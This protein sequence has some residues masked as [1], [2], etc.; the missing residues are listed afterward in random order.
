MKTVLYSLAFALLTSITLNAQ[1]TSLRVYEILQE[2]CASCHSN[3]NPQNGLDLEGSGATISQRATDVANNIKNITPSNEHAAARG[4]RYIYPGRPDRSFLFRKIN[5]GLEPLLHLDAEEM[6]NMPPYGNTQLTNE[7]KE[8]LRQ[9]ILFGA[10]LNGTVIDEQRIHDYYNTNGMPSFAEGGPEAPDPSEGFQFKMGPFYLEPGGEVEYF[11]KY[12]LNLPDDLEVK[13]IEMEISNF[14]HHFIIYS[15]TPGG[16]NSIPAGLRQNPDHSDISLVAAVQESINLKLPEGTAFKWDNNLVLDLNSHFINY[17][18]GN[19]LQ[20]EVYVNVYTQPIGTAAQEMKTELLA[21]PDIFIPN[22]GNLVTHTEHINFNLG[23]VYLWM[24]MGHT[25]KYGANYK[26]FKRLPGGV[27][28]DMIYDGACPQGIPGCV[29]PFFDYQHIPPRF[30]PSL[31]PLTVNFQ[32]GLIHEAQWINDGPASVNWGPTSDDEMMVLVLMYVEDTTGLVLTDIEDLA[33]PL[34]E[35]RVFPNP[36][37]QETMVHI[38]AEIGEVTF[39]LYD[40]VG[41]EL[42]RMEGISAKRFSFQREQLPAGMYI[43]RIED[44]LGRFISGKLIIE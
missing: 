40:S 44:E 33:N 20:A 28:G 8:L 41:K 36:M 10:P 12:E 38:P 13:R 37:Q 42:R 2:K 31:E 39:R 24:L 3:A 16:S 29:S 4:D 22:N 9:W 26:A 32:N 25:H 14:S 34:D 7:E 19:T 17:S 11:Q 43:Y 5:N 27:R 35:I 21:N 30:F 23:E 6:S 18:A 15:F 1:S